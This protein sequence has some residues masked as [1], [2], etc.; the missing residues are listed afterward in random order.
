MLKQW[1]AIKCPAE[2]GPIILFPIL[3]HASETQDKDDRNNS[4]IS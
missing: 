2:Y 3:I 4:K 1:E